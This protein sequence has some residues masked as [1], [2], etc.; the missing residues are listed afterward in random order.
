MRRIHPATDVNQKPGHE[1]TKKLYRTISEQAKRLDDSRSCARNIKELFTPTLTVQ[2]KKFCDYCERLIFSDVVLYGRKTEE[3][4]W[5]KGFYDVISTAKKLKKKEFQPEEVLCIE[6]HINAGIGYYNHMMMKLQYEFDLVLKNVV[7]FHI[8]CEMKK[9]ADIKLEATE[10]AKQSIHQCLIYLGDLNRYKLDIYPN[11]NPTLSVRY[12]LQAVTYRPD[13]GMPHNQ[14]GTLEMNRNHFLEA[15]YHYI[16]CLSCKISFDGTTNN[17]LGLFEKNSKF[18]EHLP[19]ESNSVDCIIELDK[20]ENIKRLIARF[21]LLIDIWY[22]NK[23]VPKVYNLCHQIYKNL[24]ECLGYP[25]PTVSESG[26]G[27]NDSASIETDTSSVYLSSD[28]V[29]KMIVICLLCIA[30]LRS[31]N[32]P[33]LS[34]AVAFSLGVY[35][36]LIQHVASHIRDSILNCPLNG[37]IKAHKSNGILKDL[38]SGGKKRSRTKL[39]RRKVVKVESDEESDVSGSER[40]D[41]YSSSSEDSFISDTEDVLAVSSDEE[42]DVSK[43]GLELKPAQ[44]LL[45]GIKTPK[46]SQKAKEDV[47]EKIQLMDAN[48]TLEIV[49]E[50]SC[51]ESIRIL[52]DWLKTDTEI[53]K[54]CAANTKSVFKQITNLLNLLNINMSSAKVIGVKLKLSEVITKEAK[55]PLTEDI[56]LKGIPTFEESQKEIDWKYLDE[57]GLN[58]KEEAVIRSIKLLSFGKYL[59]TLDE[60]GISYDEDKNIFVCAIDETKKDDMK[61][62]AALLEELDM[63]N[64]DV[65]NDTATS[66]AP[67]GSQSSQDNTKPPHHNN[68]R[69]QQLNK[70]KHM[71]QL[72]LAAEVHALETRVGGAR[73]ALSPYLVVDAEALIGSS[74]AVRHLVASRKFVV[75]VPTAG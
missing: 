20:S 45:N 14:M 33:Q 9:D 25:K 39:R 54:S 55:I 15:V 10:W 67:S 65:M 73:P 38:M 21:L 57:R 75:V 60:S 2:R 1:L 69:S 34:T 51:L 12:Y 37:N 17:L 44:K 16:R 22:F 53:L 31:A 8:L 49:T 40:N 48:D 42:C 23:K 61:I 19:P 5:R 6:S 56:I 41:D 43:E 58:A 36:L 24:E 70:M 32:S 59:S 68:H 28:K 46:P 71:G 47:V 13:F 72:W 26:E 74:H 64:G 62:S 4:L 27:P 52:N 50:E 3:L 66:A 63:C 11:L 35:S 29:F 7:D 30:K 18:I